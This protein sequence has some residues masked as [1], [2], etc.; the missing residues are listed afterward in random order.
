MRIL[1]GEN[2]GRLGKEL[3][4]RKTS[5]DGGEHDVRKRVMR[6]T[7]LTPKACIGESGTCRK[8]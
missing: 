5:V 3:V 7:F 2:G 6:L 8:L 4:H 1:Q